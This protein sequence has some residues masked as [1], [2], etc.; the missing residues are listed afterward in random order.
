[1]TKP[2]GKARFSSMKS[3]F[4]LEGIGVEAILCNFMQFSSVLKRFN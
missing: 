4:P 3:D 2:A 1:M